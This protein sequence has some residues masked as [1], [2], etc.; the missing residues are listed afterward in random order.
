MLECFR[1]NRQS[2]NVGWSLSL[3]LI[4]QVDRDGIHDNDG[5]FFAVNVDYVEF[6]KC[7]CFNFCLKVL[8][9]F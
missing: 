3:D 9:I 8:Y 1:S 2:G 4:L 6:I 7:V 5:G